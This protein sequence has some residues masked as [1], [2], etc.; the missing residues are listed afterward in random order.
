MASLALQ[1]LTCFATA[2]VLQGKLL[3]LNK[4]YDYTRTLFV[5]IFVAFRE[6]SSEFIDIGALNGLFVLGR[7]IGFVGKFCVRDVI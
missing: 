3:T 1:W 6:E 2:A 4:P 5:Y 7:S